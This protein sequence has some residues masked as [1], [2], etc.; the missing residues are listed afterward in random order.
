MMRSKYSFGKSNLLSAKFIEGFYGS[1]L[2]KKRTL[3]NLTEHS[4]ICKREERSEEN[5]I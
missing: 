5:K 3:Q 1:V 4:I 2:T